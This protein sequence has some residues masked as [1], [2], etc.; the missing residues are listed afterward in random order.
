MGDFFVLQM[1]DTFTESVCFDT[2]KEGKGELRPHAPPYSA[3]GKARRAGAPYP[4]RCGS[5]DPMREA[6][7][8]ST[9]GKW[10]SCVME[11]C[12]RPTGDSHGRTTDVPKQR[13]N[14]TNLRA[15]LEVG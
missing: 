8:P 6:G 9:S 3:K 10:K 7:L 15:T 5:S 2:S 11:C 4:G 13:F 12:A 1:D 14:G